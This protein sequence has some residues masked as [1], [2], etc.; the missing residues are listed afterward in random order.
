L[1][2]SKFGLSSWAK[3]VEA[4]LEQRAESFID[5]VTERAQSKA[6]DFVEEVTAKVQSRVDNLVNVAVD[7]VQAKVVRPATVATR[8][9]SFSIL[10]V[11]LLLSSSIFFTIGLFRF[12][13]IYLFAAHQWLSYLSVGILFILLGL[14]TYRF[15]IPRKN[16]RS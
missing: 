7:T 3:R 14:I 13:N 1:V 6:D 9:L 2:V 5:G 11:A 16:R 8:A 12:I 4:F 15:R 10:L